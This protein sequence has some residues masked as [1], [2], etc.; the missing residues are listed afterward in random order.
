MSILNKYINPIASNI[1]LHFQK[2]TYFELK[3]V[4]PRKSKLGDY[5]Y[6]RLTKEH[7]I[8]INNDLE[9]DAFL[10]TALHEIGHQHVQLKYGNQ[11]APHGPEWKECYRKLLL[12]A[13]EKDAFENPH[14]IIESIDN[15]GSSSSHN[16]EIYKN[17]YSNKK[18]GQF[19][20]EQLPLNCLFELNGTEYKKKK[21]NNKRS[22]CV[23]LKDQ[24]EY[25]ISNIAPVTPIRKT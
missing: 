11:V 8:T 17:L 22:I 20:L 4:S 24:K 12:F 2:H 3:I 9:K 18:E 7:T 10:F 1:L 19:F 13:L 14:L 21:Q 5:R 15:I 6:N 25:S 16:H 23:R